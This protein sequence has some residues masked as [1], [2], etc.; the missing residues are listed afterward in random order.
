MCTAQRWRGLGWTLHVF[1]RLEELLPFL[2]KTT[3]PDSR[4]YEFKKTLISGGTVIAV[5]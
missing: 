1:T 2:Y 4:T 5:R 3:A